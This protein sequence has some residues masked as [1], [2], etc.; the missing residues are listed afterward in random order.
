MSVLRACH[1]LRHLRQLLLLDSRVAIGA[2]GKGRSASLILNPVLR[3]MLP[4]ILAKDVYFGFL[5]GPSRLN[6][7][8]GPSRLRAGPWAPCLGLPHHGR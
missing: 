4:E 8:D 5:F 2:V 1:G 3:E 7:A 6:P